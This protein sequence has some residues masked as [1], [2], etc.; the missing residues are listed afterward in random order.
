VEHVR[1]LKDIMAFGV[2]GTPALLIN[3]E[4]KTVGNLPAREALKK[5]L[6]EGAAEFSLT[7]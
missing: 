5:W 3:D 4:V 1:D 7:E 6:R 2:C